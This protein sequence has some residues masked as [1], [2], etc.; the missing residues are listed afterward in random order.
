MM[1]NKGIIIPLYIYPEPYIQ[2]TKDEAVKS[3]DMDHHGVYDWHNLIECR[4]KYPKVSVIAIVNPA[5]GPGKEMDP[6][7]KKAFLALTEAGITI[8]GYVSTKYAGMASAISLPQ[9][10][11]I[12]IKQDVESWYRFYPMIDGIFFDEMARGFDP[13]VQSYYAEI[14]DY[15]KSFRSGLVVM[16]PGLSINHRWYD[17]NI[18]DIF[19]TWE[20]DSYPTTTEAVTDSDYSQ[21]DSENGPERGCLVIGKKFKK[22]D[23]KWILK[24]H[25]DWMFI[26]PFPLD[27]NPWD[28]LDIDTLKKLFRILS[29]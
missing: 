12:N 21:Q 6:V 22:H 13:K 14:K 19:I 23:V 4:K 16:N 1:T 27:P 3:G 7:F 18:A 24:T 17:N 15:A 2:F 20:K 25:Y 11:I 29:R 9:Y 10:P 8:I 26:T 5:S 28:K